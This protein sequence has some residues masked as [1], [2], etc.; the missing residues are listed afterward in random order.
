[1]IG[2]TRSDGL[3]GA[4]RRVTMNTWGKKRSM[5]EHHQ[6]QQEEELTPIEPSR[7][8]FDWLASYGN[9]EVEESIVEMGRRVRE[10]VP[11]CVG[12]SLTVAEGELTFTLMVDR[13]GAALLDALQYLDGGPCVAAV[14]A[15]QRWT[16]DDLPTDEQQWQLFARGEALTGVASTLSLPVM[17]GSRVAGG[18]NLYA[19]SADAFDGH[20]DA[21]AEA[22][23]AWAQ[24]AV[25]N[26]DLGFTSRVRAAAAPRRLRDRGIVDVATGLVAEYSHVDTTTAMDQI[27]QAAMRAG[28]TAADFARFVIAAHGTGDD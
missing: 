18:V 6:K 7:E 15:G 22:C 3:S 21:V 14:E 2:L 1:V 10:I 11:E 17:E 27:R 28:V 12:L 26:A 16:T 24:G 9:V 4:D 20:H 8:A 23:G 25:T 13:P 5:G 19:S